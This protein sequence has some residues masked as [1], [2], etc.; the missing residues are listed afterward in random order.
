MILSPKTYY[1][2]RKVDQDGS[3]E[4]LFAYGWG[5]TCNGRLVLLPEDAAQEVTYWDNWGRRRPPA[6]PNQYFEWDL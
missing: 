3:Q 6:E 2:V 4:K 5:Y 1:S